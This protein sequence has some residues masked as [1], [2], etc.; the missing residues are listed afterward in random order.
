MQVVR[1]LRNL[2]LNHGSIFSDA[3]TL[4]HVYKFAYS[5]DAAL[6]G[7]PLE[8]LSRQQRRIITAAVHVRNNVAQF[9]SKVADSRVTE[10]LSA[11]ARNDATKLKHVRPPHGLPQRIHNPD[12][13]LTIAFV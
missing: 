11:A 4:A 1:E 12:S 7:T 9:L 3:A 6:E 2:G 8:G 13:R 5:H 10:F